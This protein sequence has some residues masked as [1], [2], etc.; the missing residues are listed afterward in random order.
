MSIAAFNTRGSKTAAAAVALLLLFGVP[1]VNGASWNEA[2]Q[3]ALMLILAILI[4]AALGWMAGDVFAHARVAGKFMTALGVLVVVLLGLF[5]PWRPGILSDPRSYFHD[6]LVRSFLSSGAT[7]AIRYATLAF[8]I[9]VIVTSTVL[10][11][12]RE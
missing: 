2:I 9:T 11:L 7:A 12:Q 6:E 8:A 3:S 5:L 1:L 10:L 4:G